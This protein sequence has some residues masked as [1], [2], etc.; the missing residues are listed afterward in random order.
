VLYSSLT[1][2]GT[3]SVGIVCLV[4]I[5]W[6]V[7]DERTSLERASSLGQPSLVDSRTNFH[8][9]QLSAHDR[10]T[11]DL[12]VDL[13]QGQLADLMQLPGIGMVL[14]RRIVEYRQTYGHFR[15]V[16]ELQVVSGIG[17]GRIA[18]IRP[19]VSISQEARYEKA[20]GS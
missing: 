15:S 6:P 16:E 7:S 12:H 18:R 9:V 20:V 11:S 17:E 1:K 14:A 8:S 2:V 3:L 10:K 5:G 13:N 19:L 4:L